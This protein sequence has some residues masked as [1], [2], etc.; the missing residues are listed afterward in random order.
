MQILTQY[1]DLIEISHEHCIIV[2]TEY[3]SLSEC[4]KTIRDLMLACISRI[5]QINQSSQRR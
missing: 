4:G 3:D 1:G 5:T 2:A